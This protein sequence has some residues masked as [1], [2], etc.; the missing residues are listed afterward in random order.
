MIV[1]KQVERF[2]A[3]WWPWRH[4]RSPGDGTTHFDGASVTCGGCGT[5]FSLARHTIA[6]DGTVSPSVV[7]PHPGCSW[8][9]FLRLDGWRGV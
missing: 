6:P 2:G 3:G 1:L 9:V 4:A 7:C 8:H 5:P